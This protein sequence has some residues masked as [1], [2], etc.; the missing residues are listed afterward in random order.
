MTDRRCIAMGRG[1]K[2]RAHFNL[3]DIDTHE[4]EERLLTFL[5]PS[6]LVIKTAHGYHLI[7][8]PD[9]P[10]T[11]P[12]LLQLADPKCPGNAVRFY[13]HDD[14]ELVRPAPSLCTKVAKIYESVFN[15]RTVALTYQECHE[16]LKF[17]IYIAAKD[18]IKQ[19]GP[20]RHLT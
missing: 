20:E 8:S 16:P 12:Y 15:G 11:D 19:L 7:T 13:P 14:L 2:E 3:Y 1:P 6:A 10:V 4:V 5:A 9:A 17:G 18:G